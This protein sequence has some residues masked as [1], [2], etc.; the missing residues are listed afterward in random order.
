M[1]QPNPSAAGHHKLLVVSVDGLD[2]R[3]LSQADAFHLRIPN[4]RRLMREGSWAGG[5]VGVYPSVTWPSH[6]TLITG[7]IP[8]VHGILGNRRPRAEGGEYYWS[9][10]LLKAPTLWQA[11][12]DQGLTT[13]SVTWPVTTGA[14]IT[15]DLPEYFMRRNGGSMDLASVASRATPGLVEAISADYPSFP[16]QWVDDRTRTLAVL[17]LLKAKQPDL[18]LAHMVDLDSEEHDQGPFATNSFAIMERTDELIG[19][20]VAALPKGY[21]FALVSDHGF[22]RIDNDANLEVL[23][24]QRGI[25]GD[26]EI[27]SGCVATTDPKVADFLREAAHDPANKIGR[28]IP[29]EEVVRYA[30]QLAAT[31]AAFE[32][33]E[34]TAF[35]R[36]ASGPFLTPPPEKGDHG[37][38]PTHTGYRSVFVTWGPGI[39]HSELPEMQMTEIAAKLAALAGIR[40]R[41]HP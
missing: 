22:E 23:F 15:Y 33:A 40:F 1:E 5:V 29:H 26:L 7:V 3:Y 12:R 31:V 32:P 41:N 38:W 27:L 18:L 34:N 19:Q 37:F 25:T 11:A 16:Q 9:S 10:D 20:I 13:A 36:Q 28:E 8:E 24:N 4:I 14:E 6:T 35:G 30:P 21:D 39:R 17:Y 2:W